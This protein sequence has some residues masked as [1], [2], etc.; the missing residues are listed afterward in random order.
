MFQQ[1]RKIN[2]SIHAEFRAGRM[3]W[4]GKLVTPDKRKGKIMLFTSEDDQ[5]MHFQ[6][7]DR[8]KKDAPPGLDLIVIND[9]YFERIEKCTTGRVYILRFTSSDKKLLF[10]M[11]EPKAEDDEENI[12]KF[13]EAI[14]AKIPEKGAKRPATAPATSGDVAA[15]LAAAQAAQANRPASAGTMD[16][17][18]QAFLQNFIATQGGN[19]ERGTPIPLPSVLTTEVL[20]SLMTDETAVAE[21]TALMPEG[22]TNAEDLREALASPQIQGSMRALTQAIYS[23]QLPVLAASLGLSAASL[24]ATGGD[25]LEVLCRGMEAHFAPADTAAASAPAEAPGAEAPAASEE[26][27]ATGDSDVKMGDGS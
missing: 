4:D 6:W 26:A 25:P 14:G 13:N 16:P 11:Q 23:G 20:Q 22:Q 5:L 10:W 9:A 2:G 21:M 12:K 7:V 19:K 17:A 27:P 15:A 3:E 18:I 8:E 24:P 1:E